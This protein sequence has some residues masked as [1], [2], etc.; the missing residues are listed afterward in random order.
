MMVERRTMPHYSP[1]QSPISSYFPAQNSK[2][3]SR[4]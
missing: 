3:F 4:V 2:T 1:S